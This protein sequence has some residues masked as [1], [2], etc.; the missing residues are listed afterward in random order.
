[1][2]Q[3]PPKEEVDELEGYII[4]EDSAEYEGEDDDNWDSVS[5]EKEQKEEKACTQC[6]R[7]FQMADVQFYGD[8]LLCRF[9]IQEEDE[10][11]PY[12]VD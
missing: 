2:E 6:G 11:N 10:L 9:C 8:E 3:E 4:M 12:D 7:S 1:M 5:V